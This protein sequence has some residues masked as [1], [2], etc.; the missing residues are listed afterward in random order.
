MIT[1]EE[2]WAL[3]ILTTT[4]INAQAELQRVIS[5]RDAYIKLL[6]KKYKAI[7]NPTSGEFKEK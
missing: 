1:Q 5:A 7:F 4:A 6:E 2:S 3:S